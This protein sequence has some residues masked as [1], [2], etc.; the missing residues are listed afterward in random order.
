M[1]GSY[2]VDDWNRRAPVTLDQAKE[3]LAEAGMAAVPVE[4]T[5]VMLLAAK[6]ADCDHSDNEDWL[7]EE[8]EYKDKTKLYKAMIKAAQENPD[9]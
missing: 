7:F 3:V 5:E 1:D 8:N 2:S 4:P 6:K 9:A